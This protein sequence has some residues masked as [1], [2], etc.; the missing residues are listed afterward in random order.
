MIFIGISCIPFAY[1]IVLG[2][3]VG[4][5]FRERFQ[6]ILGFFAF[7]LAGPFINVMV[8]VNAIY[9]MDN[10]RWGKTRQVVAE[11]GGQ[12]AAGAAA[13]AEK[14]QRQEEDRRPLDTADEESQISREAIRTPFI[15]SGAQIPGGGDI[16]RP[17][18]VH[19]KSCAC[20]S[21]LENRVRLIETRVGIAAPQLTL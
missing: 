17:D 5:T 6:F 1:Y 9:G 16:V 19:S 3:Y 13:D 14:R 4:R 7:I 15:T 21:E 20:Q 12:G 10:V 2:M 18:A 8:T 11:E